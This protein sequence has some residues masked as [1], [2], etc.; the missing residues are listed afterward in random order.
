MKD[1]VAALVEKLGV[2]ERQ[3]SGGAAVLFRAARDKLGAEQF[4]SMFDRVPGVADLIGKAPATGGVGKLFGGMMSAVGGSNTAIIA[5][6]LAGFTKLGLSQNDAQKFVPVIL[7]FLRGQIGND[8]T[9]KL[10]K[11]LR[12]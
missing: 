10:E 4:D 9:D 8:A 11:T 1:L 6:V 7:D 2:D 5:S 3:A 12:S